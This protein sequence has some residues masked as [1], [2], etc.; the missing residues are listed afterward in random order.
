MTTRSRAELALFAA[1]FIWG[2]TFVVVKA[3]S[4]HISPSLFI[5]L[6]FGIGTLIFALFLFKQL[7]TIQFQTC[8]KAVILGSMLG[9]GIL[10]QNYGIYHTTASKAAFITGLM[11]IFTP[12]AQL[13]LE[14]RPPK[15]G[16]VV[17]IFI[18]TFGLYLL[19]SPSGSEINFGDVLVLISAVIFGVYIVYLDIFS[20]NENVLHLAFIQVSITTLIAVVVVPFETIIFTP[21]SQLLLSLLYLGVCVTIGT[22][23]VQ[24]R[25]QKDTT[26]TRAVIIFTIEP[27]IAA[28]L[29]Y[30]VLNEILEIT[31]IIGASL[32]VAGILFSEFS[33]TISER[34]KLLF[35]K[36]ES[37]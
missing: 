31:G 5:A 37:V 27:V 28:V 9:V 2:S 20:K 7:R 36:S 12:V 19:T 11:V 13:I 23:Y 29:A 6:R 4:E 16:N 26:P 15:I 3:S 21:N 8:K 18:V 35:R 17:G 33:E 24:T 1:T 14:R 30:F 22:T 10:L 32:I 25:F 34:F